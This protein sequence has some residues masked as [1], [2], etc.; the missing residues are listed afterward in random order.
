MKSDTVR[1]GRS[2]HSCKCRAL[3]SLNVVHLEHWYRRISSERYLLHLDIWKKPE[4]MDLFQK[5]LGDTGTIWG[6]KDDFLSIF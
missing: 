4:E 2:V 3:Y 1:E 6:K 5:K